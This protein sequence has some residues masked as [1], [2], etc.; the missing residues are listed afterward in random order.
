MGDFDGRVALVTGAS[1]GIG[2]ELCRRLASE[3]AAVAV[4]YR[5]GAE[6]AER[7]VSEIGR[8]AAAFQADLG[9]AASAERLI[10]QVQDGL[11]PVDILVANAGLSQPASLE[12]VDAAM[13]DQALAVNLRAPFLQARRVLGHMR[14]QGWGRILFTSSV[15]AFTGGVVGP[16]YASSKAGL[17]GLLHFIAARVAA[18]GVTVNAIA[19]ALIEDTTMLPRDPGGLVDRIPVGRLG[20]PAEVADLAMAVLRNSYMTN[21][22]VEIDGGMYPR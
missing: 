8:S 1:G 18:D 3:G 17:H 6:A 13:F 15:A 16:Q 19:P 12:D 4:H 21:Q 9:E 11:G 22:V 2:G 20:K 10:D 14:S 7:L 5:S